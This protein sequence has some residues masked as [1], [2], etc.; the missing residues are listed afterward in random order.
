[1]AINTTGLATRLG[2]DVFMLNAMNTTNAAN[3]A[4]GVASLQSQAQ[5]L[6]IQYVLAD[7]PQTGTDFAS[8][9]AEWV[10]QMA[11]VPDSFATS[12]C[13]TTITDIGTPVGTPKWQS[14]DLDAFGQRGDFLLP[15]VLILR[16]TSATSVSVQGKSGWQS[17]TD[18][19][20]GVGNGVNTT[21]SLVDPSATSSGR[22]PDFDSWS[23]SAPY[24]PTNW[25]IVAGTA[26]TTVS[27]VTDGFFDPTGYCV[28]F[29]G[30][31]T[32]LRLRQDV[33]TLSTGVYAIHVAVKK[34][35]YGV[36]TGT[37]S[38]TLRDASGT[39]I[40][41]TGISQAFSGLADDTWTALSGAVYVPRQLTNG[42]YLE[43]RWTGGASDALRI[44]CFSI[45]PMTRLYAAGLSLVGF[46]GITGLILD[47]D[48]WTATTALDSGTVTGSLAKGID[49]LLN[50]ATSTS[51]LP[52]SGS[53]TQANALIA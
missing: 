45:V 34:T 3:R 1:V 51:R 19:T 16:A 29:T 35:V 8:C 39:V 15:D 23:A 47:T 41:A 30:D 24:T 46:Q 6:V 10:R 44:D 33:S 49:R 20:W 21:L 43:I 2:S 5:Q 27:R 50:I 18:T 31:T 36:D 48:Q 13:T 22:D 26:G 37:I 53:P 4:T 7:R 11:L 52:T 42:C 12:T 32:A 28:Q 25:T 9:Y 14:S 17:K 38:A 40:S